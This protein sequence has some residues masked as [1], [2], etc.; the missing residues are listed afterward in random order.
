MNQ[1]RST[2]ANARPKPPQP[3]LARTNRKNST[4]SSA[5]KRPK[6]APRSWVPNASTTSPERHQRQ[7]KP[8]VP[9]STSPSPRRTSNTSTKKVCAKSSKSKKKK[10]SP[11]AEAKTSPTWSKTTLG[12]RNGKT[13]MSTPRT[14]VVKKV[15]AKSSSFNTT[16]YIIVNL[17]MSRLLNAHG[18][19]ATLSHSS[20]WE[21][22]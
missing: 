11:R 2:C 22:S 20:Y 12:N 14:E 1:N 17:K 8:S 16:N 4:K 6:S 21:P 9:A 7:R 3:R 19:V 13:R 15:A 18:C 5:K 10:T